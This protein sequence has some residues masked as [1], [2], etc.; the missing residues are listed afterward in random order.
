MAYPE[1]SLIFNDEIY[2]VRIFIQ[3]L[4]IKVAIYETYGMKWGARPPKF[5]FEE[6]YPPG[7]L[8]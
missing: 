5:S 6:L 4:L 7:H 2:P 8:S 3:K 1:V